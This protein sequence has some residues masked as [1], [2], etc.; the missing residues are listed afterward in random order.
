VLNTQALTD[1]EKEKVKENVGKAQLK[2]A[3]QVSVDVD[4]QGNAV[5]TFSDGSKAKLTSVSTIREMNKSELK[6]DID[7]DEKVKKLDSYKDASDSAR[8]TYDAAIKAGKNVYSD[9][10]AT[11]DAIDKAHKAI[12][13]AVD[14]LKD[15]AAKAK[16][17]LNTNVVKTPVGDH[18]KVDDDEKGA[19]AQAVADANKDNGVTKDKVTVDDQGNATVTFSDGSKAVV[20]ASSTT[21]DVS[22]GALKAAT[23]SEHDAVQ[24][25]TAN[26]YN[27][28]TDSSSD[29]L[30]ALKKAY[31]DAITAG[32]KVLA[33]D[34]A[35]QR[36]VDAATKNIH[37]A[38]ANL[39][40]EVIKK[41]ALNYAL[42]VGKDEFA[43]TDAK[44][45][46]S[47]AL[48]E[49]VGTTAKTDASQSA[50]DQAYNDLQKAKLDLLKGEK[51]AVTNDLKYKNAD[52]DKKQAYDAAIKKAQGAVTPAEVKTAIATLEA[53]KSGLN[54]DSK[55]IEKTLKP[56]GITGNFRANIPDYSGV[57]Q[58][59]Q[60]DD[61]KEGQGYAPG[62]VVTI[63]FVKDNVTK[64]ATGV[65]AASSANNEF[66]LEGEG[67]NFVK[68]ALSNPYTQNYYLSKD[69]ENG[70]EI[71][72]TYQEKGKLVS[73]VVNI[74]YNAITES[75]KKSIDR[76][77]AEY[78]TV[79]DDKKNAYA[80]VL[81]EA[82]E[83][84][85]KP[86]ATQN[87]IDNVQL[88]LDSA[89]VDVVKDAVA[90]LDSLNKAQKEAAKAAVDGAITT[91]TK[92]ST[93]IKTV[94][95]ETAETAFKTA[96][97]LNDN[98][99]ALKDAVKDN[100]TV[101]ASNNYTNA[102][103]ELQSAYDKAVEA[104][105]K[106]TD[107]NGAN[108][109]SAKVN[110]LKDAVEKAKNDLN[111][112]KK[113]ADAKDKAKQTIDNLH[114][115]NDAQK[116]AAKKAVDDETD[117]SKVQGHVTDATNTDTAM[118]N[119][120][121]DSNLANVDEIEKGVNFTNADK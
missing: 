75:L 113:L 59:K 120:A 87:Q 110:Q 115:L 2:G 26:A 40:K 3:D 38:L 46:Y 73:D 51:E 42:E 18:N 112:D 61:V 78:S 45:A 54:G 50:L 83:I 29:N 107:K 48:S 103:P 16:E 32:N 7:N 108:A 77:I 118:K 76:N 1:A 111:G 99:G 5:I 41:T 21:T 6:Q 25:D 43:S 102:D 81:K 36:D 28:I 65:I 70:T 68:R 30:K 97:A 105:N 117:P 84:L 14:G 33:N 90:G 95:P 119:L 79:S 116:A 58:T 57:V 8:E 63:K 4:K 49:A 60:G 13:D 27:S 35:P 44:K 15:S 114:N 23:G 62:T 56:K 53:A 55:K 85:T 19:I 104:A 11:Q 47:K 67:A 34:K 52:D 39:T 69:I 96:K 82:N 12:H 20:P 93:T 101:K 24:A 80:E 64:I 17:K 100:A 94:N 121:K 22:K 74:T 106:V 37:D 89:Y 88:K 72:I 91:Q 86:N 92:G 10:D 31:E 71:S 9:P 66:N 98:M 109:D